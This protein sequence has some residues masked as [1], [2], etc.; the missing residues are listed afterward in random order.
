MATTETA[1]DTSVTLSNQFL[2]LII[3]E[4]I[5]VILI[6]LK[7]YKMLSF[8]SRRR[9]PPSRKAYVSVIG[10]V[11]PLLLSIAV[12]AP[13]NNMVI[14][15][16]TTAP[17]KNAIAI[18]HAAGRMGKVLALQ[19]REDAAMRY[20]NR[21]A[22]DTEKEGSYDEN[23]DDMEAH[24]PIIRAIVRSEQEAFA[25]KCDIGGMKMVSGCVAQPI[26]VDWLETIV[27]DSG[28]DAGERTQKL[29]DAFEGCKAAILCDA[30]HNELVWTEECDMEDIETDYTNCGFS[31]V[32]PASE[33]RDLS[34]RLLQEIDA[35]M[36]ST[37][38]EHVVLRS[39][40]G[41]AVARAA[42]AQRLYME[43]KPLVPLESD[44]DWEAL[45]RAMGGEDALA[46]P[47]MAEKAF[48]R[49]AELC[50]NRRHTILRLGAL[51]DDAGMVPLVFGTN[52]S[53]LIKSKEFDGQKNYRPPILSRNDAARVSTVLVRNENDMDVYDPYV[54]SSNL[55]TVDCAWQLKYGRDSVGREETI[56]H[57]S[58][59]DIGEDILE[60]VGESSPAMTNNSAMA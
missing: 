23:D 46:G 52:D 58:R 44:I 53:I 3:A 18:T 37:T 48:T 25:V 9:P 12:L 45:A 17:R 55:L 22:L 54:G 4:V 36:H 8:F 39:T 1:A 51:T 60:A 33:N 21:R 31:M 42:E 59:Q 47:R 14:A 30:S 41:L 11:V 19:L 50:P 56:S 40:M 5:V 28:L 29:R 15:L 10:T 2:S 13:T 34:R 38:L 43:Q 32:V 49:L 27:I 57:A 6:N 7:R 24:L 35:T 26:K 16:S 20:K